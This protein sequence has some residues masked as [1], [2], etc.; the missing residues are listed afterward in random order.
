MI[1]IPISHIHNITETLY[2][3]TSNGEY[4]EYLPSK[5]FDI[6]LVS[7][8]RE[9]EI[10]QELQEPQGLSPQPLIVETIATYNIYVSKHT[11]KN[12][13]PQDTSRDYIYIISGVIVGLVALTNIVISAVASSQK[14]G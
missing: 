10:P 4:K 14:N 1:K 11:S 7:K 2:R 6:A 13:N 8:V 9:P 5:S 3:R 12:Q